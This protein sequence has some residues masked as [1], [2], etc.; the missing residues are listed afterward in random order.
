MKIKI[1][2]KSHELDLQD[3]LNDFLNTEIRIISLHYQVAMTYS[4]ELEYS[5][6]CLIVY[7]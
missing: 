1:I 7:E 5:F 4:N 6:S 3:D 2:E